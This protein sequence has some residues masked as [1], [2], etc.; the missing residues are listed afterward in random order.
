MVCSVCGTPVGAGAR[1]CSGCGTALAGFNP[2]ANPSAF[3]SQRLT[4]PR[5]GRVVAGVCAGFA[6]R[7]GW[8]PIVVRLV[9]LTALFFGFGTPLLAYVIAWIIM[10][11]APFAL[12]VRAGSVAS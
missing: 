5:Q 8:D 2:Y 11:N 6:I 4:R 9:L 10:P 1:F 12:P 7:Y 3:H